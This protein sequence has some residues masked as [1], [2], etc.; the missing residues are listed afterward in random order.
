M[1]SFECDYNNG[2]HPKV[3]QHLIETNSKQSLTYGFDEWSDSAKEKIRNVCNAPEADIYFLSG[4]TQTN[5][6][7]IDGMLQSYEA[8]ISAKTGHINIHAHLTDI[9]IKPIKL[10][11]TI[12]V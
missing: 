12:I 8:V 3:L 11:F 4:G 6:T 7:V 2:A 10:K 9:Q 5:M 1:I